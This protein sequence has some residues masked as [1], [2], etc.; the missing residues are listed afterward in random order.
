M[1]EIPIVSNYV[2]VNALITS[3]YYGTIVV[4]AVIVMAILGFLWWYI[5]RFKHKFRIREVI[6]GR[7]I[8]IDDWAREL[9]SR[10]KIKYWQLYKSRE[11]IPMPPADA[12][13][14]DKAGRKAVEA[15]RLETGEFVY[16]K[17]NAMLLNP[18]DEISNIQDKGLR[19]EKLRD[20]R[21]RNKVIETFQPFTTKQ[22]LILVNQLQ[23]AVLRRTNRWQDYILPIAGISALVIIVVALMIFYQDMGKPLLEMADRVNENTKMNLEIVKIF[24]EMKTDV[25]VIKAQTGGGQAAETPPP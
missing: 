18:P 3:G 7:K 16:I 22:R 2:D 8:I 1:V 4:I 21:R 6:N 11:L 9:T 10:D 24:Q 23:K 14:V 19:D 17:D 20:W 15:Y 25:Q 5:S 13:D 12:I